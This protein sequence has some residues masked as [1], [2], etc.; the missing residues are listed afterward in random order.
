MIDIVKRV[1]KVPKLLFVS[2][3]DCELTTGR[4]RVLLNE[5][6]LGI[7]LKIS[8]L[9]RYIWKIMMFQRRLIYYLNLTS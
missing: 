6:E 8:G 1:S 2:R 7:N 9:G 5:K 3:K 4:K